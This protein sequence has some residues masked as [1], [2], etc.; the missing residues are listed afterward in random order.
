MYSFSRSSTDLI[1]IVAGAGA[2]A[3]AGVGAGVESLDCSPLFPHPKKH[4]DITVSIMGFICWKKTFSV[5]QVKVFFTDTFSPTPYIG[6][7]F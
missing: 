2:G 5:A 1:L 3:G 6:R 4:T 7:L